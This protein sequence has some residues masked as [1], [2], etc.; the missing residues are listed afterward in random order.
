VLAVMLAAWTLGT[1]RVRARQP[2]VTVGAR[3]PD[4]TVGVRQPDS[5]VSTRRPET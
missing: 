5:T 2:D 4:S 1:E 3:Q